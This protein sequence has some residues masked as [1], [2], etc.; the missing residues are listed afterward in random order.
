MAAD[1]GKF[2]YASGL[3]S[4][5]NIST[6]NISLSTING[7][8]YSAGSGDRIVSGSAFGKELQDAGG[9]VFGT[10]KLTSTGSEPCDAAHYNAARI[11][12]VTHI[13]QMCR[14]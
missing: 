13:M 3:L 14:P 2:T 10:L 4:A 6:T 12:P 5:P 11:D 9:E 7:Q 8:P 1:T